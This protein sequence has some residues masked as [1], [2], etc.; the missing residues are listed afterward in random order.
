MFEDR[1]AYKYESVE[2]SRRYGLPFNL[3]AA[4]HS[5]VSGACVEDVVP[6]PDQVSNDTLHR[7]QIANCTVAVK[8]AIPSDEQITWN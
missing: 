2:S 7:E 4:D 5:H 1:P 6:K 3:A 8:R